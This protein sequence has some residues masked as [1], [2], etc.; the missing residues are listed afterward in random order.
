MTEP[1][2]SI[3][4]YIPETVQ[5][6]VDLPRTAA[7][8]DYTFHLMQVARGLVPEVEEAAYVRPGS[9]TYDA[10]TGLAGS[11]VVLD[12]LVSD[13]VNGLISRGRLPEGLIALGSLN[14]LVQKL[15]LVSQTDVSETRKR[16]DNAARVI[17]EMR[18]SLSA[19]DDSIEAREIHQESLVYDDARLICGAL[20]GQEPDGV[21]EVIVR[22]YMH[23]ETLYR[24]MRMLF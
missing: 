24:M 9:D 2:F 6:S 20:S 16:L 5:P 18:A 22:R 4:D 12:Y 11:I 19:A 3:P 13:P 10:R 8:L 23:D 1:D 17:D 21:K 7:E 14:R 15:Q